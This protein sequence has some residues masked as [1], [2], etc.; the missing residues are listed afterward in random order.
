MDAMAHNTPLRIVVVDDDPAARDS[1]GALLQNE[2]YDVRLFDSCE[3]YLKEAVHGHADCLVLDARFPSMSGLNCLDALQR[4][5]VAVR[6]V[7]VM[8]RFDATTRA[9]A[10]RHPNVVRVLDKPMEA[11]E[12][13]A[14][15]RDA[16]TV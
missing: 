15:V 10:M 7:F 5:G 1:F 12:L 11:G 14:A 3:A 13:V 16:V 6:T 4:I 9:R 8:G 2:G